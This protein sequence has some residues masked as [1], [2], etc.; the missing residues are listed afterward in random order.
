MLSVAEDDFES[1]LETLGSG[2][3]TVTRADGKVRGSARRRG[4]FECGGL[5]GRPSARLAGARC[6]AA[7]HPFPSP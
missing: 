4:A 2:T 6:P 3:R 1:V 7:A 5:A